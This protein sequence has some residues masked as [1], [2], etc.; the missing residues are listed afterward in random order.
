MELQGRRFSEIRIKIAQCLIDRD[1]VLGIGSA[2][3][4]PELLNLIYSSLGESRR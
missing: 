1:A 3:R 2:E 4:Q